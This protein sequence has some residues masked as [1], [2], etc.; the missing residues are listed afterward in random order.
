VAW[1]WQRLQDTGGRVRID[2]LAR[3][4]GASR[5]YLA[6]RFDEQVGLSPKSVARLQ[7]FADVRRRIERSPARWATIAHEVGYADQSHLNREFQQFAGT[8]PTDLA[9]RL[10]PGGGVIGDARDVRGR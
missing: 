1:A 2:A 9:D 4:L 6:R 7:R 5:R 10:I 8:T 3:E